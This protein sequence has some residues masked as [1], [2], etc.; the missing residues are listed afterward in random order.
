MAQYR[1]NGG[2]NGGRQEQEKGSPPVFASRHFTGS[3]TVEAAV[4]E[5]TVGQGKDERV[6]FSVTCSRS[7]RERDSEDWKTSPSFWPTDLPFVM[8]ALQDA[9][10]WIHEQNQKK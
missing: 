1:R 9:Y 6:T 5:K 3:S 8:L 10:L 2:G 4:W 7:Y